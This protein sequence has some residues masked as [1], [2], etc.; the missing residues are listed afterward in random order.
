M[1]RSSSK[2]S[3][4]KT[5]GCGKVD[6][7]EINTPKKIWELVGSGFDSTCNTCDRH[8]SFKFV[9][10]VQG[11][12]Q[13]DGVR[14]LIDK[15]DSMNPVLEVSVSSL[16]EQGIA[17]SAD[18]GQ[19][20]AA[21]LTKISAAG[22]SYHFQ[23]YA[24]KDGVF[25]IL[26]E[27]PQYTGANV[28]AKFYTTPYNTNMDYRNEYTVNL[29]SNT[30]GSQ[31][32][33]YL[34][35]HSDYE[36]RIKVGVER[37]DAAGMYVYNDATGLYED[38][39][40]HPSATEKYNI[41]VS[42][43]DAKGNVDNSVAGTKTYTADGRTMTVKTEGNL[44]LNGYAA[45][46][47]K[48]MSNATKVALAAKDYTKADITGK[49]NPNIAI[50]SFYSTRYLK[51]PYQER[52]KIPET[53]RIQKSGDV[54]NYLTIPKFA[55]NTTALGLRNASCLTADSSRNTIGIVSGALKRVSSKRSIFGALQNRMEHAINSNENVSENTTAAESRIRDTDIAK[56]MISYSNNQVISQFV[57][58]VLVQANQSSQGVL[59]LLQ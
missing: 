32:I 45:E 52:V 53:I 18:P 48:D 25:Y 47:I 49:E 2:L 39:A 29:K 55:L 51:M 31:S 7:S 34:Y 27:R 20:I 15:S 9:F 14:Y 35:D 54:P 28:E 4:G 41:K 3:D 17:G 58:S 46:V 19:E 59:S 1:I 42:Y 36:D 12:S 50:D 56:E 37:D 57:Q 16:I 8:Y 5:Y 6:F 33:K 22:F 38:A 11:G 30:N 13:V 21:A 40:L 43:T 44:D 23:Q 26:D 10:D 24:A